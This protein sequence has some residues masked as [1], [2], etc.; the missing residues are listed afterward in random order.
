[1]LFEEGWGGMGGKGGFNNDVPPTPRPQKG[2]MKR[3]FVNTDP[4]TLKFGQR[5]GKVSNLHAI[6]FL[7]FFGPDPPT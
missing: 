2:A 4:L 6:I 5:V 1:M 7:E 3:H